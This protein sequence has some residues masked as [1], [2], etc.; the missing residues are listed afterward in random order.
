MSVVAGQQVEELV[1]LKEQVVPLVAEEQVAVLVA[2][3]EE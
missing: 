1:A 2:E 3:A